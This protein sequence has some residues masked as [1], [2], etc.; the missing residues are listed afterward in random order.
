MIIK[1]RII[2]FWTALSFLFI[3]LAQSCAGGGKVKTNTS[4]ADIINR[5]WILT[6]IKTGA[7]TVHIT[8][9]L[10]GVNDIFTLKF[11]EERVSGAGAP[12]RYFAPYNTAEGH[13]LSIGM[14]AGTLMAPLFENED[15]KEHDY[16]GYLGKVSRWEFQNGKLELYSLNENST[17]TILVFAPALQL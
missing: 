13:A 2:L 7:D 17:E 14:I 4:F 1:K 9:N 3:L 16:F 12:N 8:R 10:A 5:D 11:D 6:D 15:L